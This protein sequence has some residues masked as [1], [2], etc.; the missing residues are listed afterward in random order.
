VSGKALNRIA[1]NKALATSPSAYTT[2][3][4]P[5]L[6]TFSPRD[7]HPQLATA[8]ILAAHTFINTQPG[9]EPH[10]TSLPHETPAHR[11]YVC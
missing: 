2:K 10:T 4:P 3:H 11:R 9:P 8:T 6:I 5:Y 1:H 7:H